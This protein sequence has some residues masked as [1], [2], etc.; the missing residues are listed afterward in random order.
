MKRQVVALLLVLTVAHSQATET[1]SILGALDAEAARDARDSEDE[2][3][4]GD[5][6]LEPPPP[7]I[8][9]P[10]RVKFLR[11]K[12]EAQLEA[13]YEIMRKTREPAYRYRNL[14]SDMLQAVERFREAHEYLRLARDDV[15]GLARQRIDAQMTECRRA[16]HDAQ[17]MM[18]IN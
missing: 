5:T 2:F 7:D 11:G 16:L 10:E 17:K 6:E 9:L 13:G 3:R 1:D 18:P 8:E 15:S 4:G 12:G 14:R